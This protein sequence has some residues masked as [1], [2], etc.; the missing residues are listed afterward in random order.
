MYCHYHYYNI[1][2]FNV[3]IIE[4]CSSE[5]KTVSRTSIETFYVKKWK[6]TSGLQQT[7]NIKQE[8]EITYRKKRYWDFSRNKHHVCVW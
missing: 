7:S 4:V 2:V 1:I 5:A 8:K 6:A 3:I